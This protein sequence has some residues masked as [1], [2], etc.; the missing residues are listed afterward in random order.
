MMTRFKNEKETDIE[1][2]RENG[3]CYITCT[4]KDHDLPFM[5][6]K[7]LVADEEQAAY[8]KEKFLNHSALYAKIIELITK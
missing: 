1:F 3:R 8:I 6:I 2:S 5:S 4:A 7:L